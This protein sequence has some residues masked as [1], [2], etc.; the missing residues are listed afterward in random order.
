MT[1]QYFALTKLK[2]ESLGENSDEYVEDSFISIISPL[3]S[4]VDD[5]EFD[6]ESLGNRSVENVCDRFARSKTEPNFVKTK[7]TDSGVF[8]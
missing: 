7:F 3:K 1:L 6:H 8:S 4:V 5:C 2:S